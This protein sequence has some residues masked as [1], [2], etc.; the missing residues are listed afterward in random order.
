MKKLMFLIM[1]LP[2]V[3]IANPMMDR[4]VSPPHS[5]NKMP[6]PAMHMLPKPDDVGFFLHDLNLTTAQNAKI[7]I[8]LEKERDLMEEDRD[9]ARKVRRD[10]EEMTLSDDFDK[11]KLEK[12]IDKSLMLHK[13][14][15]LKKAEFSHEL[16]A[17]LDQQQRQALKLKMLSFNTPFPG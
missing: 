6:P 12:L 7:L 13:R 16:Y 8:L 14:Y 1:L 2:I 4:D 5:D 15:A 10:I 3:A 11:K 9:E 17:V